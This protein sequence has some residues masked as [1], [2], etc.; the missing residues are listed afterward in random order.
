[1]R[2]YLLSTRE[3]AYELR[4][5]F[6]RSAAGATAAA[7]LATATDCT[8]NTANNLTHDERPP[9]GLLGLILSH[10]GAHGKHFTFI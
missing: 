1:M 5:D 10:M 2:D 9:L 8:E 3:S 4:D 6:H 7:A